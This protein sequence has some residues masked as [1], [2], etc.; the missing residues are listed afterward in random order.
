MRLMDFDYHLPPEL[1]ATHPLFARV[2]SR[3]LCV[4]RQGL[5]HRHFYDLPGLL[6]P[7]DLLVFNN[8]KVI[9]A[10]LFGHKATGGKVEILI[11]R[12]INT[13]EALARVKASKPPA[14]GASLYLT[15]Q[16]A[17]KII[18]RQEAF[19]TLRCGDDQEMA[20]LLQTL[21]HM[22]LPPYLNRQANESDRLRYQTVY[23]T[24]LGAIAAPTAGLHFDE[25]LLAKLKDEGVSQAFITLHV[26]S[27][28]FQPVRTADITQHKMHEE[29]VTVSEAVCEA[30]AATKQVG[31]RVVA[32]GT[33]T[34]RSLEAAAISGQIAP[35]HGDTDIFIYPGFQFKCVDAMI[36]NFHLPGSSLLMLV[37][38]F[39]GLS[40][41]K[42]AYQTAIEARYRFYSYGDA[43][44]IENK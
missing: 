44:W 20:L 26:G 18:S 38:A 8:T 1:I 34:V 39:A 40:T 5:R 7:N 16:V 31:G 4:S 22:P 36:T 13:R 29:H 32:V 12:I 6:R 37:S 11:E 21:G 35:Y 33:T 41:I 25:A 3:L 9:P 19:Y 23:A 28:T 15:P 42:Q 2:S 24:H 10:R 17:L 27:G 30:I 43:M 14:I